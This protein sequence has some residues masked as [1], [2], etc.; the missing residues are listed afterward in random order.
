MITLFCTTAL[1][2]H[3]SDLQCE[4]FADARILT[5]SL[6]FPQGKPSSL[7]DFPTSL[8]SLTLWDYPVHTGHHFQGAIT[9]SPEF[10]IPRF[11]K[12]AEGCR[13]VG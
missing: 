6:R 11:N 1:K 4:L 12:H 13:Q 3:V 9:L 2:S 10:S 8:P 5:N 7:H